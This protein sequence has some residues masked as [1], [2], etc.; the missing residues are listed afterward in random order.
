[1]SQV[2][3]LIGSHAKVEEEKD[4]LTQRR[5]DAKMLGEIIGLSMIVDD[6]LETILEGRH[7]EVH[8][9][10]KRHV[11]ETKVSEHLLR[12]DSGHPFG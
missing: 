12:V 2:V 9:Q 8:E 4:C 1:M 7:S 5:E 10:T 11:Q 6:A 3:H